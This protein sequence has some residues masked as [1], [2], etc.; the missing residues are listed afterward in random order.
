MLN[1]EKNK[2]QNI[3]SC[4]DT[5][6]NQANLADIQYEKYSIIHN[7][8][9]DLANKQ[10]RLIAEAK[11]FIT[12][13]LV[14][15]D[16][17]IQ[18]KKNY[19]S[20]LQISLYNAVSCSKEGQQKLQ[21]IKEKK[22]NLLNQVEYINKYNTYLIKI[23]NKYLKEF[24]ELSIEKSTILESCGS[25]DFNS[26]VK[27]Y[28][29]SISKTKHYTL[30]IEN[31][32]KIKYNLD[33][34]SSELQ[35]KLKHKNKQLNNLNKDLNQFYKE[36]TKYYKSSGSLI[37][38]NLC[39]LN[40]DK[41]I[42]FEINKDTICDVD[43]SI[44]YNENKKFLQSS[45][46]NEENNVLNNIR[47]QLI[48]NLRL[49]NI[50]KTKEA[51]LNKLFENLILLKKEKLDKFINRFDSCNDLYTFDIKYIKNELNKLSNVFSIKIINRNKHKYLE[52]NNFILNNNKD[53]LIHYETKKYI[54]DKSHNYCSKINLNKTKSSKFQVNILSNINNSSSNEN[55]FDT[56]LYRQ[57]NKNELKSKPR[58][59][60]KS[61]YY[62]KKIFYDN[63]KNN[64]SELL[65]LTNKTNMKLDIS[66][67]TE[68]EINSTDEKDV[69]D[70][71]DKKNVFKSFTKKPYTVFNNL[72]YFILTNTSL[73]KCIKY[74]LNNYRTEI[75]VE[76][77]ILNLHNKII[78]RILNYE[79]TKYIS[80][81]DNT[82]NIYKIALLNNIMYNDYN[83]NT[84]SS[85]NFF[86]NSIDVYKNSFK[87]LIWLFN[88][89]C[90]NL[91]NK[92]SNIMYRLKS[93]YNK[94]YNLDNVFNFTFCQN[95]I[96]YYDKQLS[97]SLNIIKNQYDVIK[98]ANKKVDN[99]TKE[100]NNSNKT[101]L[102]SRKFID[103]QNNNRNK[104]KLN[105]KN[106]IT[107]NLSSLNKN[108]TKKIINRN[109]MSI[110]NLYE[111]Y[112][113]SNNN[114]NLN[115]PKINKIHKELLNFTINLNSF[116]LNKRDT[117]CNINN[118]VD[119]NVFIKNSKD[120]SI[121]INSSEK[122]NKLLSLT[123]N[124]INKKPNYYSKID[125]NNIFL[126]NKKPES[127]K[128]LSKNKNIKIKLNIS[129]DSYDKYMPETNTINDVNNKT[130]YNNKN[131]FYFRQK[132]LHKLKHNFKS[133]LS[134]TNVEEELDVKIKEKIKKI[135]S[136]IFGN[137]LCGNITR[138]NNSYLSK[139]E[140]K[141]NIADSKFKVLKSGKK[142][143]NK[144]E[145]INK[146]N[147]IKKI[148]NIN[149]NNKVSFYSKN[150]NSLIINKNN[151]KNNNNKII[152]S[153]Y[154]INA[155][156][157]SSI[158]NIAEI[159]I[160]CLKSIMEKNFLVK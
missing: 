82:N 22:Q 75:H 4:F 86:N 74:S 55:S 61:I 15:A 131:N 141:Y 96:N 114:N 52:T 110:N 148:R 65:D 10:Y 94:T 43:E 29:E 14:K 79:N 41:N 40:N 53:S 87:M 36:T 156:N 121:Q 26:L 88:N 66:N 157:N 16:N 149:K 54:N 100:T 80:K 78:L 120:Y 99:I 137:Y 158:S 153:N 8:V 150:N 145:N 64:H 142:L 9:T 23:N 17:D 134:D 20:S 104:I 154:K 12:S 106:N 59:R 160:S 39:M 34:K 90:L 89:I 102:H 144:T 112:L 58:L 97:L 33:N 147:S 132:D 91:I 44:N 1:N 130:T 81:V 123:N 84:M 63:L 103:I 35:N 7:Q 27:E 67:N 37:S 72:K 136:N 115:L 46:N 83:T 3:N 5:I 48:E 21:L 45:R 119:R 68:S 76:E 60:S 118:K 28:L 95:T 77:R 49:D 126:K 124:N 128:F 38:K 116:D 140:N 159:K 108:N 24:L 138:N 109:K 51:L 152:Q 125:N 25:K 135:K 92:Y 113:K 31:M 139:N 105:N 85:K 56:S 107:Y 42:K 146:I 93:L 111:N 98:L 50:V 133:I 6:K 70:I 155:L 101:S 57:F 71:L 18:R 69:L 122:N 127:G 143:I 151:N 73:K 129:N 32:T 13:F 19:Y 62:N 2:R 30:K 117:N 11:T 47:N